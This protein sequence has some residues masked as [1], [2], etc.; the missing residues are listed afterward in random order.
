MD[1]K[2]TGTTFNARAYNDESNIIVALAEGS[3]LLGK[4]ISDSKFDS[5]SGLSICHRGW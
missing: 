2:V 3:V 4:Q 1:I 5:K